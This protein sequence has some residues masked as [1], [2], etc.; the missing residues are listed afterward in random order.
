MM[1]KLKA[2]WSICSIKISVVLQIA[3]PNCNL[4]NK[5]EFKS[6]ND[7]TVSFS[8]KSLTFLGPKTKD[9]LP[10]C[11]IS[12]NSLDEFKQNVKNWVL[13]DCQCRLY[14]NYIHHVGFIRQRN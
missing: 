10:I 9:N 3:N 7:K 14:K 13:Q 2:F 1:L 8:T 6:Q 11:L 12:L 5:R 4:R